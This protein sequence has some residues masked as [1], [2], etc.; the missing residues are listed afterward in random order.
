MTQGRYRDVALCHTA[1]MTFVIALLM[2][3]IILHSGINST[4]VDVAMTVRE[5]AGCIRNG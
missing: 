4:S 2:G 3:S 5:H 1:E